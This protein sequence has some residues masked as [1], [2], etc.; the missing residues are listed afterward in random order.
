MDG[1]ERLL[2]TSDAAPGEPLSGEQVNFWLASLDEPGAFLNLSMGYRLRGELDV[3]ALE[4]AVEALSREQDLLQCRVEA[5]RDGP[6]CVPAEPARLGMRDLR[7]F[8]QGEVE[9]R[10]A[11]ISSFDAT[12]P[13]DLGVGPFARFRLLQ[14]RDDEFVLMMTLHHIAFDAES[15]PVLERRLA[16]HYESELTGVPVDEPRAGYHEYAREQGAVTLTP[17]EERFWAELASREPLP[18]L[19]WPFRPSTRDADV[20]TT[21]WG[22]MGQEAWA[23]AQS[24][25]ESYSCTMHVV[26]VSAFTNACSSVCALRAED[27]FEVGVPTSM[28]WEARWA[29]V[30]GPYVHT[31]PIRVRVGDL[32]DLES[33]VIEVRERTIDIL[34]HLRVPIHRRMSPPA[35]NGRARPAEPAVAFQ[36]LERGGSSMSLRGLT[37]EGYA[38]PRLGT[39]PFDVS[40]VAYRTPTTPRLRVMTNP[41]RGLSAAFAQPLVDA[42]ERVLLDA[43]NATSPGRKRHR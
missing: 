9:A 6:R 10:V 32:G 17:T 31:S 14:L 5:G 35:S 4:R 36:Y 29:D 11:A 38:R 37:V 19:E 27:S 34:E 33:R 8:P 1:R 21:Y 13:F 30:I 25:A 22:D 20:E 7:S 26:L 24:L 41:Q 2:S 23:A 18:P 3:A 40:L 42:W 12:S 28:R 15:A 16:A 43:T 39:P